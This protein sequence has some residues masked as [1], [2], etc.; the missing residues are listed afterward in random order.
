MS[1]RSSPADTIDEYL[2]ERENFGLDSVNTYTQL[3]NP[4]VRRL[5]I[6][7]NKHGYDAKK[8]ASS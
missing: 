3:T 5:K 7:K 4:R 1:G 8:L 6:Y 2:R